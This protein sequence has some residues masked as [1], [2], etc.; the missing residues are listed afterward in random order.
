MSKL[1][2][3]KHQLSI[4]APVVKDKSDFSFDCLVTQKSLKIKVFK[5]GRL[6]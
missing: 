5:V 1:K 4:S 6:E 2:E 3:I